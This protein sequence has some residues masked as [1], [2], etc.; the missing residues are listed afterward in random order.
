MCYTPHSVPS[1]FA[2]CPITSPELN[3]AFLHGTAEVAIFASGSETSWADPTSLKYILE[4]YFDT[5]QV[6][7]EINEMQ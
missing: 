2:C 3:L 5:A 7:E 6:E 4:K 1:K